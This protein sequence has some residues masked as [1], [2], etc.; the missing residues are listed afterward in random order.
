MAEENDHKNPSWVSK[1]IK[2][3]EGEELPPQN[4]NEPNTDY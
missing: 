1:I 2:W 4:S 3:A